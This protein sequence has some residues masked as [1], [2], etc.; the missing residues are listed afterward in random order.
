MSQTYNE[1]EVLDGL[2]NDYIFYREQITSLQKQ[3]KREKKILETNGGKTVMQNPKIKTLN[4]FTKNMLAT[5]SQI[6][7]IVGVDS[8]V[9]ENE[10]L[11]F[12]QKRHKK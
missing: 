10:L 4:D 7:K 9:K 8:E 2:L 1:Q 5:I 6:M 11:E 3:I 12:I